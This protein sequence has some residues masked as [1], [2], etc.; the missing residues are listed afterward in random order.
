M[1]I[2]IDTIAAAF[3]SLQI[4]DASGNTLTMDASG[5]VGI[6][7]AGNSITVDAVALDIRPLTNADVITAE[8]GT[9]P[10]VIGDGGS[11]ITVDAVALD[12]RAL[13]NADVVTA[14]QGTSPWVVSGTVSTLPA[15]LASWQVSKTS[16]TNAATQLAATALTGRV[17][18]I[19]QNLGNQD[20]FLK[21]A[22][23]V[24]VNDLKLFKGSSLEIE[25][26]AAADLYA[27]TAS[28]TADIRVA[29]FAA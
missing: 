8:Q 2:T 12:I 21:E 9:S 11:S 29:E 1:G 17:K 22:N 19:V 24:S 13:T 26:D 27:I 10:W 25:L 23:T 4:Q 28:G 5:S 15:G 18:V 6:H 7:D 14:E 20:V 16:V 3:H